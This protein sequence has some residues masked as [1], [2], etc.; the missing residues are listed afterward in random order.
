MT[1]TVLRTPQISR[2]TRYGLWAL[3]TAGFALT[4]NAQTVSEAKL[5]GKWKL[6]LAQSHYQGVSRPTEGT[7]LISEATESHFKWHCSTVFLSKKGE[8]V[9]QDNSFD[10]AFDGQPYKL[11]GDTPGVQ[12]SYVNDNGVLQGTFKS[13]DRTGHETITVSP[14][15]TTM[16]SQSSMILPKGGTAYWI[17][18]WERS[19]DKKQH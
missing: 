2:F 12:W 3:I 1:K 16:T 15:G 19:P 13:S 4:L 7:L 18:V 6:N 14:D 5:V 17:E 9:W 8:R 11:K 10:G